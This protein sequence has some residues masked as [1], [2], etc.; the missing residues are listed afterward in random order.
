MCCA[1]TDFLE[2]KT[3]FQ[4]LVGQSKYDHRAALAEPPNLAAACCDRYILLA[5]DCVADRRCV[6]AGTAIEMPK[7]VTRLGV[8]GRKVAAA[9]AVEERRRRP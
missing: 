1:S 3:Q 9:F 7:L 8:V 5:I 6:D 2:S 4:F